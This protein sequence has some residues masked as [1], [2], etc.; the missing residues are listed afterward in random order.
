MFECS[1]YLESSNVF[2]SVGHKSAKFLALL[3]QASWSSSSKAK[4][5]HGDDW[6]LIMKA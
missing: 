1:R 6:P 3:L 4:G 5:N 2:R